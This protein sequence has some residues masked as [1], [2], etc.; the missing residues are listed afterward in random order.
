MSFYD[1]S[2]ALYGVGRYGLAR[3]GVVA[4]TVS[5]V[6]VSATGFVRNLHLDIFEVDITEKIYGSASATGS[7]GSVT[8]N[9]VE[10]LDSVTSTASVG[11]VVPQVTVYVTSVEALVET[12]FVQVNLSEK[13]ESVSAEFTVNAAG[14]DIRSINRV[15]IFGPDVFGQVGAPRVNIKEYILGVSA[16]GS[17]SPTRQK[18]VEKIQSVVATASAGVLTN[19]NLTRVSSVGIVAS[20]NTVREHITE[21]PTGQALNSS[22]GVLRFSNTKRLSTPRMVISVGKTTPTGIVFDF[23]GVRELY[24]PYR[25][26][27]IPRAA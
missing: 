23:Y 4:P 24:S 1:S 13:L 15:N 7:V 3:Y 17:S 20:T 9:L 19:S 25:T 22:I 6:G 27:L 5:L 8:V 16:V 12:N 2:D 10:K 21:R 11:I 26:I 18:L 14:L